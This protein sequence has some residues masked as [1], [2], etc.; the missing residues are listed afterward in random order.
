MKSIYRQTVHRQVESK[1][2]T[3]E[4]MNEGIAVDV[5]LCTGMAV[6][7]TFPNIFYSTRFG[8]DAGHK[9]LTALTAK[10]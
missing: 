6:S 3:D 7:P 9:D 10:E 8:F 5:D 1:D 2:T 4:A